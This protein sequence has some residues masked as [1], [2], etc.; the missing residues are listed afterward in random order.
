MARR[1][2]SVRSPMRMPFSPAHAMSVTA[3]SAYTTNPYLRSWNYHER[4]S[5]GCHQPPSVLEGGIPTKFLLCA[6]SSTSPWCM[7]VGGL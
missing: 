7:L 2:V 3:G 4:L 5:S 6:S 1:T